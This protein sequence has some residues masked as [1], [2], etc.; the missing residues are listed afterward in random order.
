MATSIGPPRGGETTVKAA[1]AAVAVAR[2]WS[3]WSGRGQGG[4]DW[5]GR[6]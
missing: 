4:S 1:A 2:G 6:G 3:G 5:S